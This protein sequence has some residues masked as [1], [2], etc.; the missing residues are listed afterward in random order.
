[1]VEATE[2]PGLRLDPDTQRRLRE[3]LDGRTCARCGG[4]AAR[5]SGGEFLCATHFLRGRPERAGAVR[6]Y[7]CWAPE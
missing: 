4:P 7:R 6:V 3:L 1:M 5:L 2:H